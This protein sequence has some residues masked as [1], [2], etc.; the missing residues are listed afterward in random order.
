[1]GAG[2][3]VKFCNPCRRSASSAAQVRSGQ[4]SLGEGNAGVSGDSGRF[5]GGGGSIG[6]GG[7]GGTSG[8]G[9]K[10]GNRKIKHTIPQRQDQIDRRKA[11][12]SVGGGPP[13]F[14]AALYGL[15]N[16]VE[17]DFNRLKQ[18]CGTSST[19]A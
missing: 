11:K 19:P 12:G 13:A 16:T 18:W 1:V 4:V 10:G 17:R 6:Q 2:Y 3:R 9:G 7:N 15:L 5:C 8:N 14:D